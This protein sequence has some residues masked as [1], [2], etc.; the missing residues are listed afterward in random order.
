[1]SQYR[2]ETVLS[3]DGYRLSV[4]I[5][6][7]DQPRA[8]IRVIHGM[9]EYQN[10]YEPFALW[11]R[12]Q[13]YTLVTADLRGH[14]PDAPLLSHIADRD[15][16]R[17]LLQDEEVLLEK[18]RSVCP[19]KPVF[20]LGHSMGTI[21]ARRLLQT[22]SQD[23]AG[24]ILSG[25]PNPQKAAAMGVRI[26]S[27]LSALEGPRAP[28]P[29]AGRHGA[30]RLLPG[31]E[32]RA[33]PAGLAVLPG[34]KLA[35]LCRGPALRRS[36]H[37]RQLSDPFLPPSGYRPA[38]A[39]AASGSASAHAAD[40]RRGEDPCTGGEAGRAESLRVLKESGFDRL[41]VETLPRMRHEI[42]NEADRE[43]VYRSM[44]SFLKSL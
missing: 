39:G 6:E 7:A 15:G 37:H 14:G 18:A 16:D 4:R 17:L 34:G 43:R 44:L 29:A 3:A 36:L 13:G 26:A 1:M 11:M 40:F 41:R 20:L 30:G 24:V 21:I 10:R 32:G 2:Q 31:S 28:S 22:R 33:V 19:G 42:L 8:V 12:D 38:S 9:E 35:G 25:Y 27:L 23:F 5:Y